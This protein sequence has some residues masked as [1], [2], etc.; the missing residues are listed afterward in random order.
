MTLSQLA[1]FI[2]TKLSSTDTDSVAACKQFLN[3]AYQTIW[4]STLWTDTL[5]VA[6]KAVTAGDNSVTL[7]SIPDITFYQSG[8]T[9]TTYIDFPVAVKFTEDGQD[10]G[11]E[12]INSDWA[13][14]FQIDPNVWND[15]ASRRAVPR[16]YINLPR[17][18]SGYARLRP[19]PIPQSDGT[20]FVLGKLKFV[21]LGD[22]DSP[23]LRGID[24]ALLAYAE[25]YMLQRA[26]QYGKANA[27]FAI[28]SEQLAIMRDIEKGQQQS[29]SR[30]V[31]HEDGYDQITPP[32]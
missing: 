29:V 31:P 24:N 9:P 15:V 8:S 10:D 11:V 2:C 6:S 3:R 17:D 14:Y 25:G 1:S 21:E 28:G 32:E 26:R 22:S 18:A 12:A 19:V 4:D 23:C 20:L 16:G 13:T 27:M 5:G 30:I 7:D